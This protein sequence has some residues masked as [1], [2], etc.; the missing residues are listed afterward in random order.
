MIKDKA[1]YML[2]G[3]LLLLFIQGIV[4]AVN[5]FGLGE[6]VKICAIVLLAA[7]VIVF[8]VLGVVF[9]GMLLTGEI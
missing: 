8:L 7:I 4:A 3:G 9:A 6:T 5:D 1:L 2:V